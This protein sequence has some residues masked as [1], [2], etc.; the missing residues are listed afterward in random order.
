MLITDYH[1]I[2]TNHII[3]D[4]TF[5]CWLSHLIWFGRQKIYIRGFGVIFL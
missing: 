5:W 3:M 4:L 1:F 2:I